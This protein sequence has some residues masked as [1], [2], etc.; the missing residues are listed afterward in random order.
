MHQTQHFVAKHFAV[1][2]KKKKSDVNLPAET[3]NYIMSVHEYHQL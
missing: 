2:Q 3:C 1:Q